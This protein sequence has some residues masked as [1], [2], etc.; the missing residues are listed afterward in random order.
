M[1]LAVDRQAPEAAANGRQDSGRVAEP[2]PHFGG[3]LAG[4]GAFDE[5]QDQLVAGVAGAKGFREQDAHD[6]A[7][8]Q[9]ALDLRRLVRVGER[10]NRQERDDPPV[11]GKDVDHGAEDDC[12]VGPE[13]EDDDPGGVDFGVLEAGD[14]VYILKRRQ[15][16]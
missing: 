7:E 15:M 6:K 12:G 8:K 14:L 16:S 11:L 9:Q 13:A 10:L 4:W 2:E 3:A 1:P 5:V